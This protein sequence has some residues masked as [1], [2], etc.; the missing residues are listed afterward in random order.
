MDKRRCNACKTICFN[1]NFAAEKIKMSILDV[2]DSLPLKTI[3]NYL[4]KDIKSILFFYFCR[5]CFKVHC[6]LEHPDYIAFI[7]KI[8]LLGLIFS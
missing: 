2:P 7:E 8:Y 3:E 6:S 4:K 1:L 5:F